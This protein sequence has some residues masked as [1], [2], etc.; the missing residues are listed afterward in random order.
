MKIDDFGGSDVRM[1]S[2]ENGKSKYTF[3]R[4]ILG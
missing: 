3:D 1:M 4:G 2:D